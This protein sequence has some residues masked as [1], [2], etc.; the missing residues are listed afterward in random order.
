MWLPLFFGVICAALV[1]SDLGASSIGVNSDETAYHWA[2]KRHANWLVDEGTSVSFSHEAL[3]EHF[4]EQ[5]AVT[6]PMTLCD[7]R[8]SWTDRGFVHHIVHPTASR[9][10]SGIG[11]HLLHGQLGVDPV[12]SLR[13]F[14][15]VA[16]GVLAFVLSTY[17]LRHGIFA[18]ILGPL[19]LLSNVRLFGHAHVATPDFL[20]ATA[21]FLS[22][23]LAASWARSHSRGLLFTSALFA[24]V[25]LATKLTGLLVVLVLLAWILIERGRR[26]VWS[27]VFFTLTVF[28]VFHIL[29]PL[30]LHDPIAWWQSF[31]K[32]FAGREDSI[33]I[34]TL[35]YGERFLHRVPWYVPSVS[36]LITA[37]PLLLLGSG[38]FLASLWPKIKHLLTRQDGGLRQHTI[39]FLWL[40][41]ALAAPLA[42]SLPAVPSHDLERLTLPVQ[43]FLVLAAALGFVELR[44]RILSA[45]ADV[46]VFTLN[47]GVMVSLVMLLCTVPAIYQTYRSHPYHLTYF[48]L[49]VGGTSGAERLGF[50]VAYTKTEVNDRVLVALNNLLPR[51]ARL[52]SNYMYLEL[53]DWRDTGR[54]RGDIR[55]VGELEEGADYLVLHARRSWMSPFEDEFYR[56]RPAPVWRLSHHGVDLVLLYKIDTG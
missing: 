49:L 50:D 19:L 52:Y 27:A 56:K 3:C 9:W 34:P 26:G 45:A 29:N 24:G 38:L 10:L 33:R 25:A 44:R 4:P 47:T 51:N 8:S 39:G 40:G 1:F 35:F 11:W 36:I 15:A 31:I 42:S 14:N 28:A 48:N 7:I 17:L 43:P 54:L 46:H 6:G 22:T 21:W 18:A 5:H 41:S 16:F 37:S 23:V 13:A 32:S 55:V 12:V 20:L 2:S 30:S 53:R